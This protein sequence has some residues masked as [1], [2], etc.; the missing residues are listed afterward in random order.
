MGG[1]TVDLNAD[2]GEG[3]DDAALL[4]YL[5]SANVACGCHA[6]DPSTMD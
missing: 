3:M 5:T 6:G 2:V 4:P 1:V